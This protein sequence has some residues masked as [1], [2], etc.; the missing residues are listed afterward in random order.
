MFYLSAAAFA[1]FLDA[2]KLLQFLFGLNDTYSHAR[3]QVL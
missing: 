2:Q 3:S 1:S